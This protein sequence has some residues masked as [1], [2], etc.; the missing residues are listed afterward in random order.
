MCAKVILTVTS[1]NLQG[2]KFEFSDRTTCII[3]RAPDCHPRLPNDNTISRYHCLLDINP[4]QIRIRDFGSKNGTYVNGK[5]IGKRQQ[6][7]T[8]AEG[9]HINFPEYDLKEGDEIKLRNIVFRVSIER[10]KDDQVVQPTLV[11]M[12]LEQSES[13]PNTVWQYAPTLVQTEAF[14]ANLP[15]IPGYSTLKWLG[16]G[17]FG[18]VYLA[19]DDK[20]G[21]LVTLK[22]MRSPIS[23][24]PDAIKRFLT[25]VEKTKALQHNH[26]VQLKDC[27]YQ[28]NNFFLT[29][30]YCNGGSV[31]DLMRQ[32]DYGRLSIDEAITIT[33][34]VLEGL[35]YAHKAQIPALKKFALSSNSNSGQGLVHRDLKPTNISLNNIGSARIAKIANYGL[36]KAFDLAGLGGLSMTGIQANSTAFMPRQQVIDLKYAQPEGD[37]WAIAAC[38]YYMLTGAFPRDFTGKDPLLAVLQ[39]N[40]VPIRERDA[41]I[42]NQLAEVIDLA[43]IDHPK[44]HF[45]NAAAFKQALISVC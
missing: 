25:E 44:I 16:I 42:P 21:E 1:G 29:L 31:A 34:Q 36:A 17:E 15:L 40:P 23:V 37:V 26:I 45:Q 14:D 41:A 13:N 19:H 7:Q 30:D 9:V 35:Q 4:P 3:G 27:G 12:P 22:I 2:Q 28:Q 39:T 10:A 32:R 6:S 43:L 24:T 20:T 5:I 8:P 33:L 38:L 11:E 18:E